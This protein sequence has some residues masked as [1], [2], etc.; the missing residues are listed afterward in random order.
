M[1]RPGHIPSSAEIDEAATD[2]LV[3]SEAGLTAAERAEFERWQAADSHRAAL[4][5]ARQAWSM[6]DRP[7]LAG[8][9]QEMVRALGAR[10]TRRRRRRL[11]IAAAALAA[12]VVFALQWNPPQVAEAWPATAK[13]IVPEKRM[14]SDGSIV[15]LRAGAEIAVDYSAPFRRVALRAGEALFHVAKD[16]TRPFVVS[17]SGVEVRAVGTAFLVAKSSSQIEVVVTE[18][19]IGLDR[20]SAANRPATAFADAGQRGRVDLASDAAAPEIEVI[21][22]ADIAARLD[23]REPRVAF[24]N[25][26]LSDAVAIMN[27]HS[28]LRLVIADA[29]LG[30]IPVNG[31]FRLGNSE[32]M[33]RLLENGFGVQAIR[34]GETV[35]LRKTR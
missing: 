25:A 22:A 23:W 27:K 14:L 18:G 3:R 30:A 7:R 2:W 34:S 32:A 13:L 10:A 16:S 24:T 1:S 4:V 21:S 9:D 12:V 5:R 8:R 15:E 28:A 26:A 11:S 29:A 6:L 19:R 33:V 35:S 20:M 17:A 31:V